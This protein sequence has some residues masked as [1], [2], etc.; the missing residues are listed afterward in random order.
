MIAY[1]GASSIQVQLL[2]KYFYFIKHE[3]LRGLDVS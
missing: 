2:Q 3:E 1:T